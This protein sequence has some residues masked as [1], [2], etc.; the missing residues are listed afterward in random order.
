MKV[1][2]Y[3]DTKRFTGTYVIIGGMNEDENTIII[4]VPSLPPVEDLDKQRF[5]RWDTHRVQTGI[6]Q[7]PVMKDVQATNELGEL[8]W[9]DEDKTIPIM[10][11]VQDTDEEG[12][13]VFTEEPIIQDIT[14]WFMTE[15]D[16]QDY[17]AYLE[18]I[19]NY[20]PEKTLEEK[21]LESQ[22]EIVELKLLLEKETLINSEQDNTLIDLYES[23]IG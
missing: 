10:I 14:E 23:V 3:K 5:Y 4:E 12:N 22:N 6:N 15:Q 16:E 17:I 19:N 20:I 9:E 1:K 7:I 21:L 13:L 2:L 8:L 18:E 11:P